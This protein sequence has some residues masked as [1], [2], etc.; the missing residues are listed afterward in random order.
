V[1]VFFDTSVLVAAS[2]ES[3]PHYTQADPALQRVLARQDRGFMSVHSIAEVYSALTRLP[4]RPRV[5][6]LEA[7]RIITEDILPYFEIVPIGK[8]DYVEALRLVANG[9]WPGGKIYDALLVGCATRCA[10]ERIYTFNLADFR[11]LAPAGL[12]QKICAP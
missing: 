9:G 1:Q 7:A 8:K 3:H 4:V 10:A 5:H 6:P 12:R 11:Q 2:E